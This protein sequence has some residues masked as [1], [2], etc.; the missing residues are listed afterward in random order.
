M[1]VLETLGRRWF[2]FAFVAALVWAAWPDGGWRRGLRFL[3]ISFVLSFAAEYAST[4]TGFPYGGYEYIAPTHGKELYLS[5]VPLFV[6]LSFGAVVWSG[7]ALALGTRFARGLPGLA[8]GG[9]FF[10]TVIDAAVDPMTLIGSRWFLGDLY[11]YDAGGSWF[12][13][14]WSNFAGWVLV[15]AVIIALDEAAHRRPPLRATFGRGRLLA[16]GTCVFFVVLA[17]ATRSWAIAAGSLALTAVL[18]VVAFGARRTFAA[19]PSS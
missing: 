6:P 12:D 1:I 19:E 3:A 9:A 5:N 16:L 4:R 11:R 2:A 13:V 8:I 14:P 17:L 10:A 7:R 15:S 18:A